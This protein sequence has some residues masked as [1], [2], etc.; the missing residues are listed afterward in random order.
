MGEEILTNRNVSKMFSG[1]S[2]LK[3]DEELA[4]HIMHRFNID[5]ETLETMPA[6]QEHMQ[7]IFLKKIEK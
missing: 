5:R 3:P 1:K 7:P 4:L 6:F 2:G